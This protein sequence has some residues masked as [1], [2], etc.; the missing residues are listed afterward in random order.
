MPFS[1]PKIYTSFRQSYYHLI[2]LHVFALQEEIIVEKSLSIRRQLRTISSM[3]RYDEAQ[4]RLIA[5]QIPLVFSF[6]FLLLLYLVE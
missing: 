1:S 4:D 6:R 3:S 2:S 5:K